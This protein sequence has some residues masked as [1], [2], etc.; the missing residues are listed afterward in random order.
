LTVTEVVAVVLLVVVDVL[1][2]AADDVVVPRSEVVALINTSAST[3]NKANP[4]A[5]NPAR[6][7]KAC[8]LVSDSTGWSDCPSGGG[9]AVE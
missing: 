8:P 9:A 6:R 7:A 1:V 2:G 3:P 4:A 5:T